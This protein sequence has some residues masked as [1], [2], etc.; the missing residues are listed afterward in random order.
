MCGGSPVQYLVVF[1][2]PFF[3]HWQFGSLSLKKC[4][5]TILRGYFKVIASPASFVEARLFEETS[6]D[7]K[8]LSFL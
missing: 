7:E 8:M 3:P 4:S 6:Y 2:F 5:A 1:S